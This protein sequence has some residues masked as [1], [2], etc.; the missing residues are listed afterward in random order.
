MLGTEDSDPF[1]DSDPRQLVDLNQD[2][3]SRQLVNRNQDSDL[4]KLVDQYEEGHLLDLYQD[5]GP[6]KYQ[7]YQGKVIDKNHL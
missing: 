6:K 1:Q 5:S 3:D 2:S 4:R 7:D